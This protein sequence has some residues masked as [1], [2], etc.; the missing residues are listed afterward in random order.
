MVTLN[1][2]R[3]LALLLGLVIARH[4]LGQGAGKQGSGGTTNGSSSAAALQGLSYAKATW[5]KD[6]TMPASDRTRVLCYEM[7]YTNSAAQPFV[8]QPRPTMTGSASGRCGVLDEKH[9]LLMD[10]LLVVAV[11]LRNIDIGRLKILNINITTQ[12][13]TPLN[14]N[15]LRPSF[16]AASTVTNL[17]EERIYFLTW[18]NR[19]PGDIIPTVSINVV[20]TPPAPGSGWE[21][22]TFYP[23]G[24]VV[25]TGGNDG[26]YYATV[27]GGVS[28]GAAPSWKPYVPSTIADNHVTWQHI[29]I[30]LPAGLQQ[31]KSWAKSTAYDVGNVIVSPTNAN[32]YMAV[33]SDGDRTTG[34]TLP[35]FSISPLPKTTE[36]PATSKPTTSDNGVLWQSNDTVN[37]HC[38]GS[39]SQSWAAD[40]I[41]Q[42][43]DVAC[44]STDGQEYKV[45]TGGT[46]GHTMPTFNKAAGVIVYPIV[47]ID[48]GGTPPP[49]VANGQPGDQ[50][51][52]LLTLQ[53]AQS[54]SL[55]YYNLAAGIIASS[56]RTRTFGFAA[57]PGSVVTGNS[58]IP[59][60]TGSTPL[61]DP[62]LLFTAYPKPFDA[63]RAWQA[64]DLVPG[65]SFGL[66]LT[67]PANNFYFGGSSEVRRHV[68][69]VY[70]FNMARVPKLA[71]GTFA[72]ATGATPATVQ[73]FA[74]GGFIGLTFNISGFIQGLVG[75]GGGKSAAG[76]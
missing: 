35:A 56:V 31:P 62:V 73:K 5:P 74:K 10:E 41:Y 8:L 72:P 63:E 27:A 58:G 47:W 14:P 12:Q 70:G 30:S 3:V 34:E 46:S 55:S 37:P 53:L 22:F 71:P 76:Q 18:P 20:Y 7:M 1:R 51:I 15:P 50:T 68:Q 4:A 6:L 57:Q 23:A 28:G 59:Q 39:S 67:A 64:S 61:I 66:S 11:D 54:H 32:F 42:R 17:A 69:L 36:T 21:A 75:G 24:S 9:P 29:G 44:D 60:E 2:V 65:I 16:G 40:H 13:G 49:S 25:T 33:R 43:A 48:G 52:N 26:H 45:L 19:L 38:S